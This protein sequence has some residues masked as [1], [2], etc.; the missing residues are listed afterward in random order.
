MRTSLG[1]LL[2]SFAVSLPAAELPSPALLVLNKADATLVVI[3]PSTGKITGKTATGEGPHEM[4]VNAEGSVA[5]VSNYGSGSA[6]GQSISVID[7]AGPTELRRFDTAPLQRPHG[8][9]MSEG[10]LWFTAE[11]NKIVGRYD[12]Q[13][14]RVD[15]LLGTGQNT[16]HMLQFSADQN[17]LFTANIGSDSI[18]IFTR[19]PGTMNWNQTVVPVGKGPE[20]FDIAP[21]GR[22]LWA[23][24]S[25]D[26][27][28]SVIDI[29]AGKVVET[30]LVGTKRSNRLKFTPDGKTVLI[31]DL[32]AGEL[33]FIDV[34]SRKVVKRLA[35][36]QAPEGILIEPGGA[37][38]YVAVAGAD[39]VAVIDLSTMA[40]TG[41]FE[42]GGAP[43]GM[44]WIGGPR[45]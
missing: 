16:T 45:R 43:D 21:D 11:A 31:S 13:A 19:Q 6:P 2:L 32:E 23:A 37:R 27:A 8:L 33:L 38:A 15:Y 36:G 5:F 39:H 22:H 29:A 28:V 12:P 44:A 14:Q 20:A 30:L 34:A 26:G 17:K 9:A 42:T 7:L 4:V 25:R 18:S 10:K 35:L 41:Q 3:D 1:A 40:K 24:H